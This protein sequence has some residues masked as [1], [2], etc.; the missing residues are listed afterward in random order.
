MKNVLIIF[1]ILF[2][3]CAS[4]QSETEYS[5]TDLR[6]FLLI[7]QDLQKARLEQ[8]QQFDSLLLAA[9]IDQQ[10]WEEML[11]D[12]HQLKDVDSLKALYS[13]QEF[14]VFYYLMSYRK[15]QRDEFPAI[16]LAIEEEYGMTDD[17]FQHLAMRIQNIP[18]LRARLATIKIKN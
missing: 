15:T 10:L 7:N 13:A 16:L 3:T 5:D 12:Y 17:F 8:R 4:A 14:E 11:F 2:S 1:L 18:A 9:P 6:N